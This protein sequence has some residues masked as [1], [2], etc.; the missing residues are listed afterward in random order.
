MY[1][2]YF[3]FKEQNFWVSSDVFHGSESI[4]VDLMIRNDLHVL[5]MYKML[6]LF[7]SPSLCISSLQA[8]VAIDALADGGV[9]MG[10]PRDVAIKLAAQTLLVSL[11]PLSTRPHA[12]VVW[13]NNSWLAFSK[14]HAEF[15]Y[16]SERAK[17][18]IHCNSVKWALIMNHS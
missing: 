8:Y 16:R 11:N 2:F 1:T 10:L 9:K 4:S 3:I 18:M 15:M 13:Y 17:Q 5:W 14:K 6:T 7:W 12:N